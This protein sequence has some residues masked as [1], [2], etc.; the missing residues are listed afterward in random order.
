[1]EDENK[2]LHA[3][4]DEFFDP[5]GDNPLGLDA[6]QQKWLRVAISDFTYNEQYLPLYRRYEDLEK[7]TQRYF[8]SIIIILLIAIAG[9]LMK[10]FW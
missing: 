10:I 8:Y 2:A 5:E 6:D 1:M 7:R 9:L 4:W 3:A